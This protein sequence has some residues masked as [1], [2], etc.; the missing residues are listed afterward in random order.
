MT[1]QRAALLRL[2]S[3]DDP[4]TLALLKAQLLGAGLARLPELREL[5]P[6]AKGAAAGHLREV[7]GGIEAREADAL[8]AQLCAGFGENG[9]IENAAWQLAAAFTPGEDFSRQR[10]L[11]DAWAAEVQRRLGKAGSELDRIETLVEYLGHDVGLRGDEQ[12][13]YNINH[14]LLPEVID[15]RRGIPIT[16]SLIYLLVGQRVGL[17]FEGVGLPGHFIVRSG[18]HFFDPFH[19]GR[20]LGV[21]DCRVIAERHGTALRREHL[22]T[23]SP[24]QMLT[25]MLGNIVVLAQESDPP[26]AA[27]VTG[28]IEALDA[29]E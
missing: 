28:W 26:L 4:G 17:E 11:L 18:E 15:T 16:L 27:K 20:R 22:R 1:N 7:I 29:S 9:D 10:A 23:V 24:R 25:R 5:L 2:L 12:D 6:Q 14:S 21:D 3:D 13:Y 8:F 19:I